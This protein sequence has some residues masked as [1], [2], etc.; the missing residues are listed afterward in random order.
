MTLHR[1]PLPR[2]AF[3]SFNAVETSSTAKRMSA[4]FTD[5]PGMVPE[6]VIFAVSLPRIISTSASYRSAKRCINSSTSF[7]E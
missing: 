2:R 4:G 5:S 1:Q 7:F 3:I 6:T